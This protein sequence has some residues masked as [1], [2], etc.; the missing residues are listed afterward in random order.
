MYVPPGTKIDTRDIDHWVF[1]VGTK[2]WKEFR[3]DRK[4]VETLLL[5]A[6][7]AEPGEARS[8]VREDGLIGFSSVEL[9]DSLL[10][11]AKQGL[12]TDP[13]A[14]SFVVPGEGDVRDALAYLHG[15][16]GFC[17]N[18]WFEELLHRAGQFRLLFSD[19]AREKTATYTMAFGAKTFHEIGGT[20]GVIV[21]GEAAKEPS[22]RED[23]VRRL[24]PNAAEGDEGD[25]RRQ[26]HPALGPHPALDRWPSALGT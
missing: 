26:P 22:V 4:L 24:Q 3:V 20:K 5:E 9:S 11:F 19:D 14:A 1:P 18:A 17:H 10:A 23:D 15:N 2:T 8:R 16:C 7:A 25:R 12:F 13:P 6:R 21:R